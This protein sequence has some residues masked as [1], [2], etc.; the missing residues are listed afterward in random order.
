MSASAPAVVETRPLEDNYL[1]AGYGIWSW[2]FT[3]DH[4]RIGVM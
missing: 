2:L 3:T 4:K 1:T